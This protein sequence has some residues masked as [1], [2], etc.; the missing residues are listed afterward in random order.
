MESKIEI[1]KE[2]EASSNVWKNK[3]A[4]FQQKNLELNEEVSDMKLE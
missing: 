3:F 4:F 1:M 2:V